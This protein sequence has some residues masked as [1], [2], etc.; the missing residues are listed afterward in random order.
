MSWDVDTVSEANGTNISSDPNVDS[1][2]ASIFKEIGNTL[3]DVTKQGISGAVSTVKTN[4][5]N[6]IMNSPEGKAQISAYKWDA[7]TKY[8]PWIILGVLAYFVGGRLLKA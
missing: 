6:Q 7:V 5:A 1:S 3:I 4:L 2:V 8:L